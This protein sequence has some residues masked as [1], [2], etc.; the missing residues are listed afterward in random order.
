MLSQAQISYTY[1]VTDIRGNTGDPI[2]CFTVKF[3]VSLSD[4]SNGHDLVQS[5]FIP[6]QRDLGH[7]SIRFYI[8]IYAPGGHISLSLNLDG[9]DDL[10]FDYIHRTFYPGTVD[11]DLFTDGSS[12][13]GIASSATKSA[14]LASE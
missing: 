4:G 7:L 12:G 10:V 13:E 6:G 8:T 14:S 3:M 9:V 11:S 5:L 2:V 1:Q